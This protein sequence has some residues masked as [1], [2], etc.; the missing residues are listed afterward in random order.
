[1]NV[2]AIELLIPAGTALVSAGLTYVGTLHIQGRQGAET[3]AK[4]E[5]QWIEFRQ[6]TKSDW[7]REQAHKVAVGF[8]EACHLH[9][10]SIMRYGVIDPTNE[11]LRATGWAGVV[12]ALRTCRS[13]LYSLTLAASSEVVEAAF[14][15]RKVLDELADDYRL[16]PGSGHQIARSNANSGRIAFNNCVRQELGLAPLPENVG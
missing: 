7:D 5:R 16:N 4:E 15:W 2:T 10:A 12:E 14:T 6:A 3:A 13:A 8:N 9:D 1:M 11:A